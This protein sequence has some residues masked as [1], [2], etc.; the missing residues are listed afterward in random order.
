MKRLIKTSSTLFPNGSDSSGKKR[1]EFG[2]NAPISSSKASKSNDGTRNE[3]CNSNLVDYSKDPDSPIKSRVT[4]KITGNIITLDELFSKGT[5][6][7][8]VFPTN[9]AEHSV[10]LSVD[11]F[12]K[13]NPC[14]P[15]YWDDSII[16][17][18]C[19]IMVQEQLQDELKKDVLL[20]DSLFFK[21]LVDKENFNFSNVKR[22]H[23]EKDI[24]IF[25]KIIHIIPVNDHLHW[26]VFIVLRPDRVCDNND[27]TKCI[28]CLDS[29]N[30]SLEARESYAHNI[31]QYLE[32]KWLEKTK[33]T[34]SI[35]KQNMPLIMMDVAKQDDNVSC[36]VF[37]CLYIKHFLHNMR[38]IILNTEQSC[39]NWRKQNLVPKCLFSKDKILNEKQHLAN[40][41]LYVIRPQY[42]KDETLRFIESSKI[43][44]EDS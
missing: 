10:D 4:S 9:Q 42:V 41:I 7:V 2:R 17:M 18:Y 25:E 31:R 37:L 15:V 30:V 13:I 27:N 22:W 19:L 35:N 29:V 26:F 36:G 20:Y 3:N 33:E 34:I 21:K 1:K 6:I 44:F 24:N 5:N 32:H 12:K 38:G 23:K 43:A 8:C 28:L 40:K 11:N 14:V 16:N 39:T